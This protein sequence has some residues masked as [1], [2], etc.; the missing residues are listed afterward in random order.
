MRSLRSVLSAM[1]LMPTKSATAQSSA[2][3]AAALREARNFISIGLLQ[4]DEDHVGE[5]EDADHRGEEDRVA[6]IDDALDD[7][8]EVREEA[9]RGDRRDERLRRPG[10]Q[11]A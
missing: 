8:R 7:R 11:H 5:E 6:E 9:E 3:A 4:I 10:L 2:T 1:T